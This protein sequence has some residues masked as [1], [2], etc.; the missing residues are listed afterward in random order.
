MAD[1]APS[2]TFSSA[3]AAAYSVLHERFGGDLLHLLSGDKLSEIR[4]AKG[5]V[6][7]RLALPQD[8]T[9]QR[10]ELRFVIPALFP[11]VSPLVIVHPS[12]YHVWPHCAPDGSLC[13]WRSGEGAHGDDPASHMQQ[14]L[15]QVGRILSL[16][17][18]QPKQADIEEH[19]AREWQPYWSPPES[20]VRHVSVHGYLLA[21]TDG[22]LELPAFCSDV[23]SKRFVL[24]GGCDDARN[25]WHRALG[26]ADR[27][28][29][30]ATA[31]M[32]KLSRPPIG[33]PASLEKLRTL[34]AQ[35][36]PSAGRSLEQLLARESSPIFV[37]FRVGDERVAYAGLRLVATR[38]ARRLAYV[39][40]AKA[41]RAQREDR[42]IVG[43]HIDTL[44]I[45][46]ADA[47]WIHG[48]GFDTEAA[49]LRDKH[50]IVIGCGSLGGLYAQAL[51]H[52][53][54][55]RLTLIDPDD[56]VAA[57]LGRHVLSARHLQRSKAEALAEEIRVQ[58]PHAQ[59][60]GIAKR[61]Q[62][63]DL[64]QALAPPDLIVSTTADW[65]T[66]RYLM[67]QHAS[68]AV[69][70]VQ[71]TWS[72]PN[73]IAGQTILAVHPADRPLRLFD[74]DGEFQRA[75]TRWP[76]ARFVLPGC[77]GQHQPNTFNR[78]QKISAMAVEQAV[79]YLTG[80]RSQSEH[81][82]WFGDDLALSRLDGAWITPGAGGCP[83]ERIEAFPIP[84]DLPPT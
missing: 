36:D 40:G 66:D 80:W 9:G 74:D 81:L 79:Q 70:A 52:S 2:S 5:S 60:K 19:F 77:A 73:A 69:A 84:L 29:H 24:I 33:A 58:L 61:Y 16:L 34:L 48:R 31:L 68:G 35:E 82:T 11:V 47:A 42:R 6:V 7:W 49:L 83:R 12:A 57:N 23:A 62:L 50:V 67:S 76:Q 22:T 38:D 10:R 53:G 13:L 72:E 64:Q 46:R 56:L 41:K 43:W 55:G 75:A 15:E 30:E 18:P 20:S 25:R 78:L 59:V 71:L 4:A 14:V 26:V 1:A 28:I 27:P 54:V 44:S 45:E 3:Q 37:C 21:D 65:P 39:H 8:H 63:F 32:V 17:F 51:A